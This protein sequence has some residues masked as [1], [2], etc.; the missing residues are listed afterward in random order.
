MRVW[1]PWLRHLNSIEDMVPSKIYIS[2]HRGYLWGS[3][4]VNVFSQLTLEISSCFTL[5]L[6]YVLNLQEIVKLHISDTPIFVCPWTEN[7]ARTGKDA[8]AKEN[9]KS[10][11][12]KA[13]WHCNIQKSRMDQGHQPLEGNHTANIPIQ[14][15]NWSVASS[16]CKV[17]LIRK[18]TR[19]HIPEQGKL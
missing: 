2:C 11:T 8:N 3:W 1:K 4:K 9:Q 14:S 13:C 16:I 19:A 7:N 5:R 17:C 6:L 18:I 15:E 10:W 12:K